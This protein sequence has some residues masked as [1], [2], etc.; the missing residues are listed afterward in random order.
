MKARNICTLIAIAVA[1]MGI[2]SYVYSLYP[3]YADLIPHYLMQ[4]AYPIAMTVVFLVLFVVEPYMHE[5][6]KLTN[7]IKKSVSK[8]DS[9]TEED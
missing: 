1:I 5:I 2:G 6:R 9:D 3:K 7:E 8:K 4:V